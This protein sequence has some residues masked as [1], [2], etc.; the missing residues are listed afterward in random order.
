MDKRSGV[1]IGVAAIYVGA[2]LIMLGRNDVPWACV[3]FALASMAGL[4]AMS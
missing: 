1:S 2:G 4:A 3:Q